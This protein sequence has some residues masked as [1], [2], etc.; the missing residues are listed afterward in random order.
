MSVLTKQQKM[1]SSIIIEAERK[2]IDSLLRAELR[3]AQESYA[4]LKAEEDLGEIPPPHECTTEWLTTIFNEAKQ[5]VDNAKFLTVGQ[6]VTQKTHWGRLNKRM[7]PHVTCLQN[8]IAGIPT[9]QYVYDS[10][11]GT[12][13]YKDIA[14]LATERATY[15]VP[16]EA[17]EHWGKIQAILEAIN[18]LRKWEVEH[19]VV[20]RPL[21]NL[22]VFEKTRFVEA[23]A[24]GELLRDHR[25]DNKPYLAD[26]LARQRAEEKLYR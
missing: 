23:W 16:P 13:Y 18:D 19:D 26:Y 20:K 7:Q 25:F 3:E 14:A 1:P 9:E 11:I 6:R 22:F 2:R 12:L 15:T 5:A 8:F 4:T 10:Q 17:A 24:L 21:E